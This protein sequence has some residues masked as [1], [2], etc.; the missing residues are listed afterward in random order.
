M[1]LALRTLLVLSLTTTLLSAC[2]GGGTASGTSAST[3]APAALAGVST[4]KGVSVVT[5]N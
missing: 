2:G 4:P 5:A 3:P 1:I